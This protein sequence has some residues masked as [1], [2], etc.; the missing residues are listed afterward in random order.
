[1]QNTIRITAL[2]CVLGTA[3]IPLPSAAVPPVPAGYLQLSAA[4]YEVDEGTPTFAVTITRSSGNQGAVSVALTTSNLTAIGGFDYTP[5]SA[6]V[7]FADGDTT[8]KS[9]LVPIID[10][11]TVEG[12]QTLQ[13]TLA[14]PTNAA[15]LGTPSV[16]ILTIHDNEPPPA[17]PV[18]SASP[19]LKQL[20]MS[21]T[22]ASGASS[23]KLFYKPTST[24]SRYL[25]I[26]PTLPGTSTGT[27]IDISVHRIDWL[28]ARYRL[29]ACNPQGCTDSNEI[30]VT[31]QM[32][33]T[34]GFFKASNTGRDDYFG[35]SVAL[36][37]DGNT[38]A[39]GATGEDS[40]ARVI[41]G[42]QSTGG[43]PAQIDNGA[44]SAGA[45]YIFRRAATGQWAQQAYVKA[46][47]AGE[48]DSFG[49][50]VA[51]SAD[52]NTLAVGAIGED[53][54]NDVDG[55]EDDESAAESG[56]VYVFSREA[57]AWSEQA[58][59]KASN[60]Y[61][62]TFFGN[63][64]ALSADGNTL[65]VGSR[66]ENS[67]ATGIDGPQLSFNA[68]ESGAVYVFTRA[69]AAWTQQ[70]YVKASNTDA[71]D[72]FG[73]S[74]A[75]S[76][77]GDTLAVGAPDERSNATDIDTAIEG[78][79]DD[80]SM[81]SAGAVYVFERSAT[82][83]AWQAYVKASNTGHFQ[84]FGSAV[85]LS[86]SG[87]LLAVGAPGENHSATGINGDDEAING[88]TNDSGAV[89][90]FA[91]SAG[92]WSKEAYVKAS[93]TGK[94]DGFGWRLAFS[95]DGSTLAVRALGERSSATGIGGDQSDDS[96]DVNTGA[97]Y[98]FER[99]SGSWS[100]RAYVK[101]S[102]TNSGDAFGAGIALSQDGGTLA[103]TAS[104]EDASATGVGGS[105]LNNRFR[106]SGALYL[107]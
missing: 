50:A 69:S 41:E 1:M 18:L 85:A 61:A 27:T 60:V 7:T 15:V 77:D 68:P 63:A 47:N 94:D 29:S 101:A 71:G 28:H 83:W 72:N 66:L 14:S 78:A 97:A 76:A 31:S 70:A 8:P 42:P 35:E 36:S 23:Y 82:Q 40:S 19:G 51:L 24:V 49:A 57:D 80:N 64:V 88:L 45:V 53:D 22:A 98:V 86:G 39:V 2:L 73:A 6:K 5:V 34:I 21:W 84:E 107:Y 54:N 100:Q 81:S 12:D 16:A 75:L 4:S 79:D 33:D 46:S 104:D 25:Q 43:S 65:A 20:Q 52:G 10:D 106:N 56:A 44:D 38:L 48:G 67:H 55:E 105:Q 87:D 11:A 30:D 90:V 9:V 99:N 37:A 103:V 89:Y 3:S 91:R 32:L 102:N 59:L 95:A 62:L 74:V 93:N 96:F 92:Q 26:G 13:L 58:R 17:A